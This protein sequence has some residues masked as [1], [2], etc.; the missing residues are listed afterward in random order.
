MTRRLTTA[1]AAAGLIALGTATVPAQAA[2]RL[3]PAAAATLAG[4]LGSAG[5]YRDS[6]GAM[7]VTVTSDAAAER[8]RAEGG[9]A[10][11]VRWSGADLQGALDRLNR[12]ALIAGTAWSVD[13][14]TNQV[15]IS[16]DATVTG[17]KR[18]RLDA[19]TSA[20]GERVRVESAPGTLSLQVNGGKAIYGGQYRCSAGF[21]V[22]NGSTYYFLTAGHCTNLASVWYQ[23]SAKTNKQGT[24]TGTS[25][26]TNDYGIVK[27]DAGVAHPG[28]VFLYGGTQEITTAANAFVNEQVRRSGSTTQVRS[29]K[30]TGLNATVNYAEGTVF[31]MIKTNVCAEGGDSGGPLFDNTIAL[32][33]TS[34]GNGNCTSGGTTYF[35]PVTEAL[36][37]YNVSIF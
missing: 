20:L 1:L 13:P 18:T 15:V 35:Q 3:G 2:P 32:G 4:E 27:Y 16:A 23:N 36:T 34:G 30:V 33:L 7:V 31:G 11:K 12:D 8:V 9:V 29:G 19:V 10:Q 5:S 6:A 37:A 17:D 21:N 14:T 22:R 25:F 28:N 24:R 26:P